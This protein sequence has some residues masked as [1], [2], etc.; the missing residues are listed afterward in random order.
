MRKTLAALAARLMAEDGID[1][2]ALAKRKAARQLGAPDT[3]SLPTDAEIASELRIYQSLYQAE[4]HHNRLR[5]LR[6][7]AVE[8]MRL[9]TPFRI[10]LT[11]AVLDGTAGRHAGIELEAFP[12]SSKDIE[13]FLL[14]QN[15]EFDQADSP[16]DKAG[17]HEGLEYVLNF[18]WQNTPFRLS[19][20]PPEAERVQRH[21]PHNGDIIARARLSAVEALLPMPPMSSETID[22]TPNP[23][24]HLQ[25][26]S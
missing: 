12:N 22:R 7:T 23:T 5:A 19:I 9:L 13:L 8:V 20:Y 17:S 26:D 14:N 16:K 18:E 3:E 15:I 6:Q 25:E 11:G 1:D 10:Y 21:H 4:E 2:Y 24:T